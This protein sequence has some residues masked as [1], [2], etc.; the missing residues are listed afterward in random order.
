M[1][2]LDQPTKLKTTVKLKIS[3]GLLIV[4]EIKPIKNRKLML[5][6]VRLNVSHNIP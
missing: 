3:M 5:N 6:F 1:V 4:L 2:Y